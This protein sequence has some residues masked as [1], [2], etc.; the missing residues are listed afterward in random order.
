MAC[1]LSA[2][3]LI[4]VSNQ[5]RV[6]DKKVVLT[7]GSFDLFHVGQ[8]EFLKRSKKLG[9]YLIVG[10]DADQR[11]KRYKG[12]N[13]PII[14]LEQRIELLLENN[15]IDFIFTMNDSIDMS[16]NYFLRLYKKFNPSFLTCGVNFAYQKDF[17]ERKR[18]F[19]DCKFTQITHQYDKSQSTTKIIEE[20]TRRYSVN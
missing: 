14:P 6:N 4:D 3:T 16:N 19:R 20:I 2:K 15:S 11:I 8:M 18:I 5:L 17:A 9:D 10:V 1:Y 7:H 13:R 12:Q